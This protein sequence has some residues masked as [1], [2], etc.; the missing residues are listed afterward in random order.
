MFK[1]SG[2]NGNTS[3]SPFVLKID[4]DEEISSRFGDA[5]PSKI[6]FIRI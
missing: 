5:I 1:D 6:S 2:I 4:D 3:R